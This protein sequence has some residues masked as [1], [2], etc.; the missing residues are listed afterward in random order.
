MT[1]TPSGPVGFLFMRATADLPDGPRQLAVM[2]EPN[3]AQDRSVP[4]L[5]TGQLDTVLDV[6]RVPHDTVTGRGERRPPRPRGIGRSRAA[7]PRADLDLCTGGHAAVP[8][9]AI[10]GD[11]RLGV[12]H[13]GRERP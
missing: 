6:A 10:P 5:G 9:P 12:H 13:V 3:G 4:A 2:S 1:A 7:R 8:E 11:H